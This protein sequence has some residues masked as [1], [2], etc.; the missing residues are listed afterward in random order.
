MGH[1]IKGNC[2]TQTTVITRNNNFVY[3][4]VNNNTTLP[5]KSLT[6]SFG[7]DSTDKCSLLTD[8]GLKLDQNTIIPLFQKICDFLLLR[9]LQPVLFEVLAK[10]CKI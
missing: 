10:I 3:E 7:G 9:S 1:V 8:L 6:D 5:F 4:G 2:D